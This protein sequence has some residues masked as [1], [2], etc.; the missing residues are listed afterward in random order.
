MKKY[1]ELKFMII[2]D[3]SYK[4]KFANKENVVFLSWISRNKLSDYINKADVFISC[5]E[6]IG[7]GES[8]ILA[9][10]RPLITLNSFVNQEIIKPNF[11]GFLCKLESEDYL[12]SIKTILDNENLLKE[13]QRN[14]RQTAD[15][16]YHRIP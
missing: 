9:C 4:N 13:T 3:G 15:V 11:N 6:V 14:A 16:F 10:A 12:N 8:E 1:P 7:L 5:Q 2:G